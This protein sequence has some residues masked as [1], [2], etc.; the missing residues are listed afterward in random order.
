MQPLE[1]FVACPHLDSISCRPATV[2]L[3]LA[4]ETVRSATFSPELAVGIG[5]ICPLEEVGSLYFESRD[6]LL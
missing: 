3:R 2:I 5:D 6:N 1:D 4:A